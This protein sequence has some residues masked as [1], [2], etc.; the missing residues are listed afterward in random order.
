MGAWGTSLFA[1]DNASDLREDYRDLIGE[2]LSGPQATDRL[3][4]S[5]APE[6]N[7][8]GYAATFWL[9]L[10]AT[11][12]KC[13][14]LEERVTQRALQAVDD[15]S[16]LAPWLGGKDE[17]K[18]RAILEALRLQLASPQPPVRKIKR[19]VVCTCS[20]EPT[21]LVGYTLRSSDHMIM[22]V[23]DLHTDKGGTYPSCEVLDWQGKV[24]PDTVSLQR[25]GLRS[26]RRDTFFDLFKLADKSQ[27]LGE[28]FSRIEIV[29]MRDR[30]VKGRFTRLG[31]KR[32]EPYAPKPG[33]ARTSGHVVIFDKLDQHLEDWFGFT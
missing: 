18:R 20:W 17:R 15:G 4:E 5:W 8:A 26:V 30:L 13:G 24:T 29:G 7:D 14:D 33:R 2:G 11:Q 19:R 27:E 25:L 3:I 31:L 21:E 6:A 23:T 12:W 32:G 10:A 1:D 9:A 28:E 22:R 16:A